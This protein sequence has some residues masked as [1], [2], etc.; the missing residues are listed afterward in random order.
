MRL[1]FVD[2]LCNFLFDQSG[3]GFLL[4]ELLCVFHS[5]IL[6][7][8]PSGGGIFLDL[9]IK[10]VSEAEVVDGSFEVKCELLSP[11]VQSALP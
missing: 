8:L 5:L 3:Y 4:G 2:F 7:L 6:F 1:H 10:E 11:L 9:I